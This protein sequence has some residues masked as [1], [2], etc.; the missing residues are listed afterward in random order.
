[1]L[2]IYFCLLNLNFGIRNQQDEIPTTQLKGF[3]DVLYIF[4]IH[5][6]LL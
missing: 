2:N 6:F 1:M 5:D 3:V 4:S